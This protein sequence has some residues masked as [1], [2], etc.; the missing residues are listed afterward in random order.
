VLASAAGTVLKTVSDVPDNPLGL[1]NLEQNWGNLVVLQHGP[2]LYSMVAH[3]AH[4]SIKVAPGQVVQAQ[5]ELGLCGNSGRSAQPHVHFQLQSGPAVGDP[6]V[7]C[8]F[9]DAV[10]VSA[11]PPQVV[12]ALSPQPGQTVRNLEFDGERAA[13][14]QFPYGMQW[15]LRIGGRIEQVR[16]D[17][18]LYGHLLLRSQEYG[19]SLYYAVEGGFFTAYDLVGAQKSVLQLLRAA[20]SRVPLDASEALRWTDLL[21]ARMFRGGALGWLW[22]SVMDLVSPFL[23]HDSLEV[24]YRAR[25]SAAALLITGESRRRDRSGQPLLMTQAE[26]HRGIGPVR[27]CVTV[28]GHSIF[29]YMSEIAG[30]ESQFPGALST[31]A[32]GPMREAA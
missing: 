11:D 28:R 23:A 4:G 32:Q 14:F 9:S 20:L 19:A 21:P 5:Q 10:V 6:T 27:A 8:R 29:A 24:E 13:F 22:G 2:G 12:T 26:L 18:D 30:P 15:A 31:P 25:R 7:A 16:S 1:L 17:I 3:L